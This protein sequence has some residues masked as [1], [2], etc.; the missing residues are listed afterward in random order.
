MTLHRANHRRS[1]GR[2]VSRRG[3]DLAVTVLGKTWWVASAAV[4]LVAAAVH[5]DL[6]TEN[7][8]G[9]LAGSAEVAAAGDADFAATD[10]AFDAAPNVRYA[11]IDLA[12]IDARIV[13]RYQ[14]GAPIA[15]VE[16]GMR[17]T[18]DTQARLP[19]KMVSLLGPNGRQTE[20]DRFEYTEHNARMVVE[21]GQIGHSLAVFNLALG[22]SADLA[23]YQLQIAENG[24][25]RS[26]VPLDP[27]IV[28][29]I[30][31]YPVPLKVI[32]DDVLRQQNQTIGLIEAVTSLEYGVYRA[33]IGRHLAVVTVEITGPA[34]GSRQAIERESWRL[35]DS[36]VGGNRNVISRDENRAIRAI[37]NETVTGVGEF[38]IRTLSLQL[39]FS[40]STE[41][42]ELILQV[43]AGDSG[44]ASDAGDG[45]DGAITV[46][47]FE[48]QPV[49]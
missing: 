26:T 40:Y 10:S 8:L 35:L 38:A 22:A 9:P 49:E 37:A 31:P 5:F 27:S 48:V 18:T 14:T 46:A 45:L 36:R 43:D 30:D 2:G 6:V 3:L 32:T 34:S 39:V 47:E 28:P 29:P 7:N 12:V 41:A 4:L 23:D 20:L 33:P 21:P 42:S 44:G 24:R 17:N 11:G 19:L 25:W 16:L 1:P 15:I 13:P